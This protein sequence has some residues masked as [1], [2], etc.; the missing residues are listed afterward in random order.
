MVVS[1]NINKNVEEAV[2]GLINLEIEQIKTIPL[3]LGERDIL[4]TALT[5]PGVSNAG[6]GASG[7][8]VRGGKTDQNLI[9]L[10]DGVIYNP[11]HFFGIF[12]ALNP[13]ST[14]SADIFKG[15]IPPEYGGR[16]SSVFDIKTKS[17]NTEAFV[18]LL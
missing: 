12:S 15:S 6:E 16:L 4:K 8:N 17:A 10:D 11:S 2:T 9:L 3:V 13:F 7:F 14:G 18:L 1:A 5:L